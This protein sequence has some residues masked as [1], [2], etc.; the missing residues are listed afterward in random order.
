M[1]DNIFVTEAGIH[2]SGLLKNAETYLPFPP[3]YVGGKQVQFAIGRHSGRQAILS[4][5]QNLG[6]QPIESET[7]WILDKIKSLPADVAITDDKLVEIFD[8]AK[9][10]C[11]D[12]KLELDTHWEPKRV[13]RL[14]HYLLG[15]STST[16]VG[17]L[18]RSG[19][20]T[21]DSVPRGMRCPGCKFDK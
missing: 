16:F 11:Q 10:R 19:G 4:K 1:G 3:E 20:C 18:I 21:F 15:G 9:S 12:A 5:L 13:K 14:P 17:T 2:Q 6:H 7:I 8:H